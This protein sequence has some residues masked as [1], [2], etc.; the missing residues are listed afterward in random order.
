MWLSENRL[1]ITIIF[2]WVIALFLHFFDLAVSLKSNYGKPKKIVC[3]FVSFVQTKIFIDFRISNFSARHRRHVFWLKQYWN[4]QWIK[5]ICF[6]GHNQ[7]KEKNPIFYTM[8][9][10]FFSQKMAKTGIPDFS[11]NFSPPR[12]TKIIAMISAP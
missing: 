6:H 9:H 5:G 11:S 7:Q 12:K 8:F 10:P 1:S 2:C 4:N 3:D